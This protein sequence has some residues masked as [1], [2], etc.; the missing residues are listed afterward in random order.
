MNNTPYEDGKEH[1][2][3]NFPVAYCLVEAGTPRHAMPH[4]LHKE[5]E[6]IYVRRGRFE[7]LLGKKRYVV[8]A[9]EVLYIPSEVAHGGEGVDCAYESICFDQI[10]LLL[11]PSMASSQ[12]NVLRSE[13]Y[14]IQ[15][16][17]TAQQ[18][19]ILK[20]ASRMFTASRERKNG[21]EMLVIAGLYDFFGTAIQKKYW[22]RIENVQ[23][24]RSYA[25]KIN[26]AISYMIANYKEKLTLE[27]LAST[28]ALS[29]QYFCKCFRKA[30]GKTPIT[31]L[32]SYRVEKACALL[33]KNDSTVTE[34]A[35][36]CGFNDV[37][38]F[39]RCFKRYKGITPYQYIKTAE[40]RMAVLLP[41]EE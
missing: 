9:G 32:N 11:R 15:N 13:G 18:P 37:G 21:W 6:L 14:Q 38:Y 4:H 29:P 10:N 30:T 23:M 34:V 28:V 20:C 25:Q 8:N 26:A 24:N 12:L 22:Q 1:R 35:L 5:A 31:Y 39:T 2:G 36:E 16:L 40:M 41:N 27:T 7:A 33:E 17:F 3:E 19:D